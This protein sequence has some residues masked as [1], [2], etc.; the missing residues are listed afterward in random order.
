MM[1]KTRRQFAGGAVASTLTSSVAAS[2]VTTFGIVSSTGWSTSTTIP[3]Y[4]V[5]SP[6]TS[7]EEKMLV[8]LSSNVLTIVSRAVDGTSA[9]SHASGA[10]VYPVFT[11]LDADEANELTAKYANRG[12]IIYQGSST[13]EELPKGTQGY[14]LV[15]GANDPAWAQVGTTGIADDAITAAKILAGAVG[16]SEIATGAVGSD[17]L[18]SDSV[19][20]AKILDANV[21]A[22]KLASD[23]VTTAKILDAN[24]T[25]AKLAT[26]VANALVP[27]GTITAYAGTT[28]PTGWLLCN[29]TS[30]TGYTALAALVGVT[31]PDFRGRFLIGDNADLTLLGTGGSTT[32]ATTNLPA[33]AH[34]VGTLAAAA[35]ATGITTVDGGSHS[36]TVSLDLLTSTV[37][38]G[39]GQNGV[40]MGGT[41]ADP[42][43][44]G[45]MSTSSHAGHSHGI[46]DPT[47]GHTITGDTAQTGGAQAY[48]Q[49]YGVVNYIIK[50][51]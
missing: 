28:A 8:T 20:T 22:A 48:Y 14:P 49:P 32:I 46:T 6:Q 7:S 44:D 26:A 5:V 37:S 23:S 2:G 27:V 29:G 31:T 43:G 3:F 34:A 36:H 10:T 13:F 24:V 40:A 42:D 1:P 12:S 51:D 9:A 11:A 18:A 21:T 16:S 45:S 4:V 50:H 25:L 41:T 15:I 39:H 35:A 17:E 38:H 19:I 47:H 33:H 30:T